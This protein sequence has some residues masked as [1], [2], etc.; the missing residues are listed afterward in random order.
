MKV[1]ER[2]GIYAE[3]IEKAAS[4]VE[5]AMKQCGFSDIQTDGLYGNVLVN[6]DFRFTWEN[7][8]ESIIGNIFDAAAEFIE[9]RTDR[10][11]EY[12]ID[13]GNS[14]FVLL[15]KKVSDFYFGE[16]SAFPASPI[17]DGTKCI[18]DTRGGDT[19]L[20]GRSGETVTVIRA[21]T[22]EEADLEDVGPM[23]K[24]EFA[25]GFSTDAFEDELTPCKAQEGEKP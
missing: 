7:P 6:M 16:D 14:T 5:E 21:L 11:V 2:L 18:F 13:G 1:L 23:Y 25:D 4:Q 22:E 12:K 3:D 17:A 9:G 15:D 10:K 19:D 20:N 8:T 24:I